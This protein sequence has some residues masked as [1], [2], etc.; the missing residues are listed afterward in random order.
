MDNVDSLLAIARELPDKC[1]G[2]KFKEGTIRKEGKKWY[3]EPGNIV[4]IRS[5]KEE[6]GDATR[7]GIYVG[8]WH[9][10]APGSWFHEMGNPAFYVPALDTFV[11]GFE[12]WWKNL[13]KVDLDGETIDDVLKKHEITEEVINKTVASYAARA[14]VIGMKIV[15]DR[16]GGN[17]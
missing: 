1:N 2:A 16:G 7:V 3:A 11:R 4:V 14:I 10:D 12:S 8:E 5:V 9:D 6:H 13:S 17:A 15:E